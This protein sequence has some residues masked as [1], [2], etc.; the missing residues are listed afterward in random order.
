MVDPGQ[1]NVLNY[2]QAV[3]SIMR[4]DVSVQHAPRHFGRTL[5]TMFSRL[6]ADNCMFMLQTQ[7]WRLIDF[8]IAASIGAAS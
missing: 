1:G 7:C 3:K 6:S 4:G 2:L 5:L 8:G